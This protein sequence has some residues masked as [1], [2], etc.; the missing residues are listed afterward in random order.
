MNDA[1]RSLSSAGPSTAVTRERLAVV[2]GELRTHEFR[3]PYPAHMRARVLRAGLALLVAATLLVAC[4]PDTNGPDNTAT[5]T[6]TPEPTPT[7]EELLAE[8][9][10]AYEGYLAATAEMFAAETV[11][12]T[13]LS[14][15][16]SDTVAT[17]DAATETELRA[18]GIRT[19]GS[20]TLLTFELVEVTGPDEVV[21]AACVDITTM[22]FVD[23]SG[24]DVSPR[25]RPDR[26]PF[27]LWFE[28]N[29]TESQLRLTLQSALG[30]G[31]EDPC[32]SG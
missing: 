1:G 30:D 8:A 22:T 28:R 15:W 6:E 7:D 5:P 13:I 9:Q 11:D 2:C 4:V 19:I 3:F 10:T 32:S 14:P 12:Y 17:A 18:Q 24:N 20:L 25:D 21:A 29:G 23:A 26:S 31:V 27:S 16:A